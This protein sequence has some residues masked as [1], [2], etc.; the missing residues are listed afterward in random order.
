MRMWSRL[1]GRRRTRTVEDEV[2]SH[3]AERVDDLID[4]GVPA[5]EAHFRA[6]R[7]FGSVTRHLEDSREVWRFRPIDEFSRTFR[8]AVRSLRAH[9]SALAPCLLVIGLSAGLFATTLVMADALVFRPIQLK[10][11]DRVLT[12]GGLSQ[13]GLGWDV[14]D[15]WS[16]AKSLERLVLTESGLATVEHSG[17]STNAL[18]V[19]VSPGFFAVLQA[20]AAF[21]RVLEDDDYH[22]VG[23][24]ALVASEP[25][26]R[27]HLGGPQAAIGASVRVGGLEGVVVGVMPP[28]FSY[29]APADVWTVRRS[30]GAPQFSVL[31]PSGSSWI[32][33]AAPGQSIASVKSDLLALL[34]RL[35][36][37]HTPKTGVRYGEMIGAGT[38]TETLARPN[39]AAMLALLWSTGI[40]L[41]LALASAA[42]L[43]LGHVLERR[44]EFA[45]RVALGASRLRALGQLSLEM[46]MLGGIAGAVGGLAGAALFN[47]VRPVIAPLSPLLATAGVRP[48]VIAVGLVAGAAIGLLA[49][50]SPVLGTAVWNDWNLLRERISDRGARRGRRMRNA[51]VVFQVAAAMVLIVSAGV[52]FR[53]FVQASDLSLGFDPRALIAVRV[54][55]RPSAEPGAAFRLAQQLVDEHVAVAASV[56]STIPLADARGFLYVGAPPTTPARSLVVGPGFFR[57]L[58]VPVLHGRDFRLGESGTAIVSKRLAR[59]RW[60][61]RPAVGQLLL[62]NAT[63]REVIGVVDDLQEDLEGRSED[64]QVYLPMVVNN[65]PPSLG[66]TI[67]K[68]IVRCSG[69]RACAGIEAE[70]APRIERL[71]GLM[72]WSETMETVLG[73][74]L[75]GAKLRTLVSSTYGVL[76]FILA[77]AAIYGLV[78]YAVSA[79]LREFGI[80]VA[81]GASGSSIQKLIFGY[82]LRV[83][84]VGIVIGALL[85]VP[86]LALARSLVFGLSFLDPL[87]YVAA[88]AALLVSCVLAA[89]GPARRVARMDLQRILSE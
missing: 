14:V 75:A 52:A 58:G 7:E 3:L 17:G 12:L 11:A 53:T 85:A 24:L 63:G 43:L 22:R 76:S 41:L 59:Q 88:A 42:T 55:Q 79:R 1:L 32:G 74:K 45:V 66:A 15:W 25:F 47:A 68:L 87:A 26:S 10:D 61:D 67:V 82:G 72:V 34:A 6:L 80:R 51:L 46:V 81:F 84:A 73:S 71:P 28:T 8:F 60:G 2:R 64:A 23:P 31:R 49:G 44:Q 13:P 54:V 70:L 16:Q 33:L 4:D 30:Q 27:G 50:L 56:T 78:R 83:T 35:N 57:T 38:I 39:R 21:G 19:A 65:G 86:M 89:V 77:T 18:A 48:T 9:V 69:P 5:A 29:P 36:E 37:T 20:S 40:V 62:V